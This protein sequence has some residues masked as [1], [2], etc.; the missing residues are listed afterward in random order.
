MFWLF[1]TFIFRQAILPSTLQW[2]GWMHRA[3]DVRNRS[4]LLL[5]ENIAGL[6]FNSAHITAR[7]EA[8]VL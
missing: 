7:S 4:T 8:V 1:L 5:I 3:G 6:C 2:G